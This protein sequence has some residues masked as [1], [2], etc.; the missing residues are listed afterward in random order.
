MSSPRRP[1]ALEPLLKRRL[2]I[3]TG[4]GGVGKTTVCAALALAAANR[5]V[6]ALLVEVGRDPELPDLIGERVPLFHLDPHDALAEYL[7]LQVGFRGVV[8][9]VLRHRGFRQL[10]EGAPG[11]RE[12]ISVGKV[13]HLVERSPEPAPELVVVDAPAT[14]HGLTFLDVPGVAARAVRSGPL[15]RHAAAVEALLRD[16]ERS[17]LL[18]VG[19]PEELAARE[20]VELVARLRDDLELPVDRVVVNGIERDPGLPLAPL[21]SALRAAAGSGS[22]AFPWAEALEDWE[23]RFVRGQLWSE[24]IARECALPVVP[25]PFC[26][27]GAED[28]LDDLGER[29]LAGGNA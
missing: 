10:L 5:G 20:T 19:R 17:V 8:E 2:V 18:P 15:H 22:D 29:L 26:P 16:P 27:G 4:K 6:R 23:T 28:H 14:G 13:W 24:T 21:G 9:R 1:A 12:L 7:G 11:W 25:L 3:V